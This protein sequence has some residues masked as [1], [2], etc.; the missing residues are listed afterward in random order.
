MEVGGF[1]WRLCTHTTIE[2]DGDGYV[3][4]HPI[5]NVDLHAVWNGSLWPTKQL[6]L[7]TMT[8]LFIP[9][10]QCGKY[11]HHIDFLT[12]QYVPTVQRKPVCIRT[13]RRTQDASDALQYC[14]LQISMCSANHTGMFI[15]I[16]TDCITDYITFFEDTTIP[17]R[18]VCCFP[19]VLP[20]ITSRCINWKKKE[21]SLQICW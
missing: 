14:K 20:W 17:T 5:P 1:L 4:M 13:V 16:I 11:N 10:G 15:N 7:V 2:Q 3:F 19:N 21:A 18:T 9:N 6:P 12:P 8:K